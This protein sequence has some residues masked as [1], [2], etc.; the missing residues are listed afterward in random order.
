MVITKR[1][2]VIRIYGKV[3]EESDCKK[4]LKNSKAWLEKDNGLVIAWP[5]LPSGKYEFIVPAGKYRLCA[6]KGGE[7]GPH[8]EPL[9]EFKKDTEKDICLEKGISM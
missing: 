8:R 9:E 4:P 1:P 3:C 2:K 6:Q 7:Y 5:E